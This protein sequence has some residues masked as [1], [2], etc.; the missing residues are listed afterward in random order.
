MAHYQLKLVIPSKF[1]QQQTTRIKKDLVVEV[2]NIGPQAGQEYT[3]IYCEYC[4]KVLLPELLKEHKDSLGGAN[5]VNLINLWETLEIKQNML[6]VAGCF[7]PL[8]T[9]VIAG[10][11]SRGFIIRP[12]EHP[13]TCH[14]WTVKEFSEKQTSIITKA[15][16][17]SDASSKQMSLKRPTPVPAAATTTKQQSILV[18]KFRKKMKMQT[19]SSIMEH[20]VNL[21]GKMCRWNGKVRQR[22]LSIVHQGSKKMISNEAIIEMYGTAIAG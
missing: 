2:T 12:T 15:A 19:I 10:P 8:E 16:A 4:Q 20:T 17:S 22:I 9:D 1:S 18:L 3:R 5:I 21:K 7:L 13:N 14:K 11:N 6:D